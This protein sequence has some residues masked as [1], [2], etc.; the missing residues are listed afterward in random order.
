MAERGEGTAGGSHSRA[1]TSGAHTAATRNR[2]QLVGSGV[3]G[4]EAIGSPLPLR[5]RKSGITEVVHTKRRNSDS[6]HEATV[7][8]NTVSPN[9]ASSAG[10]TTKRRRVTSNSSNSEARD[11]DSGDCGLESPASKRPRR[12]SHLESRNQSSASLAANA[13]STP[14][15]NQVTPKRRSSRISGKTG[16]LNEESDRRVKVPERAALRKS[17]RI[18]ALQQARSAATAKG[19]TDSQ[20][21]AVTFAKAST[22]ATASS[23]RTVRSKNEVGQTGNSVSGKGKLFTTKAV[24][25]KTCSDRSRKALQTSGDKEGK[26]QPAVTTK[27]NTLAKDRADELEESSICKKK[28]TLRA[29]NSDK[30]SKKES[31]ANRGSNKKKID[32]AN[33]Y[34]AQGIQNKGK[35]SSVIKKLENKPVK[36]FCPQGTKGPVC[37][38]QK[39]KKIKSPV[40]V[41]SSSNKP[42]VK[43]I[44]KAEGSKSI[45]SEVEH[46]YKSGDQ[47]LPSTSGKIYAT[48]KK[49]KT[50]QKKA[51]PVTRPAKTQ[52]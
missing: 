29:V 42:S 38:S 25:K 24:T 22:N 21:I 35:A 7:G 34:N 2:N 15:R 12:G 39:G 33:S 18:S 52:N 9:S 10:S 1:T 14:T 36:K 20:D 47:S 26:F 51:A 23:S 30:N 44:K 41:L 40:S 8:C 13:P 28:G 43:E 16:L 4:L 5:K 37:E 46:S 17:P 31:I 6:Q 50:S 19:Q 49:A 27:K 45:K 48:E 32:Q 3:E 11:A